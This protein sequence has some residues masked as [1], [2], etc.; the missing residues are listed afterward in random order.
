MSDNALDCATLKTDSASLIA[1]DHVADNND[2]Q[3][4]RDDPIHCND[5]SQRS[6]RTRASSCRDYDADVSVEVAPLSSSMSDGTD[7]RNQ[8]RGATRVSVDNDRALEL[9]HAIAAAGTPMR[10]RKQRSP[11]SRKRQDLSACVLSMKGQVAFLH[12]LVKQQIALAADE[13]ER[14]GSSARDLSAL[15]FSSLSPVRKSSVD[16]VALPDVSEKQRLLFNDR[17]DLD[18]HGNGDTDHE[19]Y[20][21]SRQSSSVTESV[22]S[23]HVNRIAEL[24]RENTEL[25][26]QVARTE[27]HASDTVSELLD[28]IEGLKRAA[29]AREEENSQLRATVRRLSSSGAP[30]RSSGADAVATS[31]SM[32]PD[33]EAPAEAPAVASDLERISE[34]TGNAPVVAPAPLSSPAIH[35]NHERCQVKIHELWQTIR[36]LKV[37]VE[38]YRIESLDLKTQRDDAVASAERAW[39]DNAALASNRNPQAKIRY[40]QSVKDENVVLLKKI[41]ELQTRLAAQQAKRAVEKAN[42]LE[43]MDDACVSD[44][45]PFDDHAVL[46]T[47]EDEA[48]RTVSDAH[49]NDSEPER[50]QLFR[51]MW[52]HNKEL[53]AEIARLR[54]QKRTVA[55]PSRTRSGSTESHRSAAPAP[56]AQTAAAAPTRGAR[57]RLHAPTRV[58]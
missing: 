18:H 20:S 32:A 21:H 35:V 41:R 4:T 52:R 14:R 27:Q 5:D 38:T 7:Q 28:E 25:R 42:A 55:T 3:C 57:R 22:T 23:S 54:D 29:S 50:S 36:N 24:E 26:D 40:L 39:R 6:V 37:Y 17:W 49:T 9:A 12:E 53:E 43:P 45:P 46:P 34:T 31:S 11:R 13:N 2:E 19:G 1:L 48:L 51:K 15:S 56:R 44:L 47:T 33:H 10:C 30:D 16:L 8:I 58:A